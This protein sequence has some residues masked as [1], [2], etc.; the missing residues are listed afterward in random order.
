MAETIQ[1][2]DAP[3]ASADPANRYLLMVSNMNHLV[4]QVGHDGQV[5]FGPGFTADAVARRFWELVGVYAPSCQC[6]K[7]LP[8]VGQD[9]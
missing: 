1:I 6:Q 8:K 3:I 4:V 5:E 9:G 2:Q 7:D